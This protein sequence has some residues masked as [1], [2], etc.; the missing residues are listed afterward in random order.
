MPR[1]G[2]SR[3]AV[4]ALA[5]RLVDDGGPRG[6]D[7]LTLARVASAAGVATPSLYKHVASLADLRRGVAVVAVRDLT[8]AMAEAT[9][10]RSGPDAVEHLAHAWRSFGHEHPGRYAATQVA[11]DPDDPADAGLRDAAREAVNLA[12]AALRGFDLP[13]DRMIDAI[14]VLRASVHG[15]VLLELGGGLR[16]P[17]D[18]DR[19]FDALVRVLVDGIAALARPDS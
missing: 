2:L 1:A 13:P 8:R 18:L 10:G 14:R 7:D 3:D 5:L 15:F 4:V 9:I 16:L 12:A 11:P 17:Q 6:F 19:S